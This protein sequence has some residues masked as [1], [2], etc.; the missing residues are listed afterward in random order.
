MS[1]SSRIAHTSGGYCVLSISSVKSARAQC[2]KMSARVDGDSGLEKA[3][4]RRDK[5]SLG[6]YSVGCWNGVQIGI[7]R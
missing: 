7:D 3:L 6:P 1:E 4:R 2:K 5:K